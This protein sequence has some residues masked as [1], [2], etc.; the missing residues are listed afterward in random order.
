MRALKHSSAQWSG[1]P[2][3]TAFAIWFVHFMMLWAGGEI[4]PHQWTAHAL[5]WSVTAIALLALGVHH[6]QLKA[7]HADGGLPGWSYRLGRGAVAISTT[8]VAFTALPSVV[9]LP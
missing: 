1:Q 4:W 7:R 2:I 8:A 9:F 3:V 6:L 5:A